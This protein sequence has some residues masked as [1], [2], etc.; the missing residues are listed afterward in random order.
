MF[1]PEPQ[2][3][4]RHRVAQIVDAGAVAPAAVGNAGLPQ[5]PAEVL[6][7]V[8]ERQRLPGLAGEEPVSAGAPGD[9]GVIVSESVAQRGLT[10]T[11]RSL[12]PLPS[13]MHKTPASRSTS[14]KRSSRASEARRPQA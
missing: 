7:D 5:E 2:V 13:R 6:V 1:E 8:G 11:C 9:A 12:P 3:V 4:H 10:G 14:S